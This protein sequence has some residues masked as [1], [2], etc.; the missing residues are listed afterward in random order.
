MSLLG[1]QQQVVAEHWDI[2]SRSLI[3]ACA[4][5]KKESSTLARELEAQKHENESLKKEI[6]RMKAE[7]RVVEILKKK[8]DEVNADNVE[9]RRANEIAQSQEE[10]FKQPRILHLI[11]S[12]FTV[13]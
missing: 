12:K 10:E 7:V 6:E 1:Q 11:R 5:V 8:I 9:M 3:N 4:Q 2:S 13:K